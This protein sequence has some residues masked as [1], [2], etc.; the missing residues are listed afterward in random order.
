LPAYYKNAV[1]EFLSD[2]PESVN[3]KLSTAYAKDGYYQL[4]SNQ[5]ESWTDSIPIVTSTMNELLG[6]KTDFGDW[7]LLLEY[8]LYRLRKRIDLMLIS[9]SRIYVV[10]FKI[11][12]MEKNSSD[13]RQVEEYAFD[14]RDFHKASHKLPISPILCCTKLINEVSPEPFNSAKYVQSVCIT[15]KRSLASAIC[16]INNFDRKGSI[17]WRDWEKS[18]YEPVP[19]IIEAAT[20]IFAG[21]NVDEISRSDAE[22]L[23]SCANEV[24]RLI[25]ET[26]SQRKKRVIV[27]TGVP[28]SGKTLAGLNV[29]HQAKDVNEAGGEVVYLS[30]N[31]P[32]VLVLREALA[33]DEKERAQRRGEKKKLSDIRHDILSRIQHINDF[34]KEY[35]L[36]DLEMPPFEHA[37][38]FDEAQRA[39]DH[40]QGKKKFERDA[41][42]PE[43][44]MKIMDRH[45][46]WAVIVC[47]VGAGQEINSGEPGM[48]LWGEALEKDLSW[49]LVAPAKALNG[50]E[51]MAGTALFPNGTPITVPIIENNS[52]RLSIPLRSYRSECVSDWVDAVLEDRPDDA[53]RISKDLDQYPITL[54]RSIED[55]RI[56]LKE[57]ARGYRRCGLMASAGASRLV[58]EG[59]GA[60]LTV[61][62]GNKIA[63][64]YLK[65]HG[66]F[67][68]SNSLEVMANEY[69]SQG[70]ELDFTGVCW[71]GDMAREDGENGWRFRRLH[72]TSWQNIHSHDIKRYV[73]N[74]YR[75]FLTRAREGMVLFVPRGDIGDSSRV[76]GTYDAV[77]RYLINC[78]V[79]VTE[80]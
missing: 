43:L 23:T 67:R 60:S 57:Y 22:N 55:C 51:G 72:K 59:L 61:Q 24:V 54:V 16:R 45:K 11:G 33:Q 74:K 56:K 39:W 36:H 12:A 80:R 21:H 53:K 10:E 17:D 7:G 62:D 35:Y 38:V 47:L 48:Q 70:L 20:T 65:P 3:A 13:I 6:Q 5:I 66:D 42:E 34:L 4:L 75:V 2:N 50:L 49:E 29:V 19:T 27:V 69:T 31:T 8:P 78:G 1:A 71:G 64:W 15:S 44:L 41:S 63:H 26:K 14:L 18:S 58:A 68:S 52:L 37:I 77:A 79:R 73:L 32:L 76:P 9:T 25:H 28:G 46:D 40:K 30:G